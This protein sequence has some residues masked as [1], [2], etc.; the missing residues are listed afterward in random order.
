MNNEELDARVR[1][2]F[3][4]QTI[5]ADRLDDLRTLTRPTLKTTQAREEHRKR[6]FAIAAGLALTA[7]VSCII[8]LLGVL[9]WNQRDRGLVANGPDGVRSIAQIADV[10]DVIVVR[11]HADWCQPSQVARPKYVDL[12]ETYEA[13][14]VLFLNFNLTSSATHEQARQLAVKLGIERHW[15]EENWRSGEL[16]VL[17]VATMDVVARLQPDGTVDSMIAAVDQALHHLPG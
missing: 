13:D 11:L 6:F 17:D 10:A 9:A 3:E 8:T 15:H 2:Y 12:R 4:G 14:R 5:S 16:I 1:D 7:A